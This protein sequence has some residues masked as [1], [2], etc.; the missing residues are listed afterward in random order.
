M[1]AEEESRH[2]RQAVSA[3]VLRQQQYV[4]GGEK[5]GWTRV[6]EGQLGGEV[7]VSILNQAHISVRTAPFVRMCYHSVVS[8]L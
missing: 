6:S 8:T 5:C 3:K 1:Y 2:S 4:P 7:K